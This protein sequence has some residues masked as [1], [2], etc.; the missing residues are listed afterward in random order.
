MVEWLHNHPDEAYW[1]AYLVACVVSLSFKAISQRWPNLA[2][3]LGGALPDV[4]RIA[5]GLRG[6]LDARDRN[7]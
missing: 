6:M 4:H 5:E 3:I 2:N 7:R 1:L